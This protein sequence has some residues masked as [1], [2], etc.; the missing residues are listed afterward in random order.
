MKMTLSEYINN[1]MGE[2]NSVMTN[3]AMIRS[4]YK[5]KYDTVMVREMG[6]I[7]YKIYKGKKSYYVHMKVPSE[8]VEDF[9][10]DVVIEFYELA[11][12]GKN[13]NDL[14]NYNCRFFSN[15]PAFVFTFAHAFIKNDLFINELKP[16]MSDEAIKKVAK[17]KNPKDE[18][19]Y[20][21]S[22]YFAY[23][24]IMQRSLWKTTMYMDTFNLDTLLKQIQHADKKIADRQTMGAEV[25]K[26]NRKP[27]QP[28]PDTRTS[29]SNPTSISKPSSFS[30]KTPMSKFTSTTK[31]S[32][33][34]KK[35]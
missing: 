3:R 35:K 22:I 7:T 2:K 28:T 33:F 17:E 27:K 26:R 18:I 34:V 21:K 1:P 9:Y 32:K 11:D 25:A 20:V 31:T 16:K 29:A 13:S 15:D 19:G 4:I 8:V 5:A 6:K 14:L 23:L 30:K 10:Y 12:K 24:M